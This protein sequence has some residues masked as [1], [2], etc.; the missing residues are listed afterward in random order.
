MYSSIWNGPSTL[1]VDLKFVVF[2]FQSLFVAKNA[3]AQAARERIQQVR[4]D[5]VKT[6]LS[7]C[8]AICLFMV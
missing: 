3:T 7:R 8:V 4:D 6:L 1:E 2:N 5:M